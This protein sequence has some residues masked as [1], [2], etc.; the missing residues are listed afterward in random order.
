MRSEGPQAPQRPC[1]HFLV[2]LP[3]TLNELLWLRPCGQG[4]IPLSL[5]ESRETRVS[6]S[7]SCGR[8]QGLWVILR[9]TQ[10]KWPKERSSLKLNKRERQRWGQYCHHSYNYQPSRNRTIRDCCGGGSALS[11][12]VCDG[13]WGK[14]PHA[15]CMC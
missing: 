3:L 1:S 8:F 6:L 11:P 5:A 9:G 2:D 4:R 13:G 12:H 14:A 10:N 15:T 7:S